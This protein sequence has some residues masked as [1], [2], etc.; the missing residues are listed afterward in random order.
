MDQVT[1]VKSEFRLQQWSRIIS[2][3][4]SSGQTVV[5]WCKENGINI[6]TYYYWLRKQLLFSNNSNWIRLNRLCSCFVE[7]GVT[8]SKPFSGKGMVLSSCISVWRMVNFNG[9][10]LSMNIV[11]LLGRSFDGSWKVFKSSRKTQ[12]NLLNREIFV[13]S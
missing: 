11:L 4:Q 12:S 9:L 2:N 7:N 13:E 3:C 10:V 1:F 6:K 5:S 8:V